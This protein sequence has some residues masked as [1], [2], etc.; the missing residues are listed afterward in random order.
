MLG[1]NKYIMRY[2][3]IFLKNSEIDTIIST[4]MLKHVQVTCIFKFSLKISS[5]HEDILK[6]YLLYNCNA[7]FDTD[8]IWHQQG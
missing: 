6:F 1:I 2:V 4:K 5:S 7:G 3:Y 8:L